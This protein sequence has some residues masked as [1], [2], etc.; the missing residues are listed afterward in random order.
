M[1]WSGVGATFS[2]T[3]C[4]D[5][6]LKRVAASLDDGDCPDLALKIGKLLFIQSGGL[7]PAAAA[8]SDQLHV[9][10]RIFANHSRSLG[11]SAAS[12]GYARAVRILAAPGAKVD[13][14]TIRP[15]CAFSHSTSV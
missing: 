3:C 9:P 8:A 10:D 12:T 7:D 4:G 2:P 15:D 11:R 13:V 6:T 14:V 1:S 5:D